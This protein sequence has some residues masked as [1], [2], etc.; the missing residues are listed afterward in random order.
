MTQPSGPIASYAG[1][2]LDQPDYPFIAAH[3][4]AS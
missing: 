1:C 2:D 3:A 4:A